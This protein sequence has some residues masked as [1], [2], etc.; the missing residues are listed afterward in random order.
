MK[1]APAKALSAHPSGPL[2]GRV[3]VPGDKSISHRS[4]MLGAL[5]IG[6]TRIEGLLEGDDV[7]ATAAAMRAFGASVERGGDGSWRV[8]GLGTAGCSS[9]RA[10]STAAMPA[11]ACG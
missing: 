6:E 2:Q 8:N 4:L 5:A 1:H 7:L 3:T 10:S 9:R 11:P